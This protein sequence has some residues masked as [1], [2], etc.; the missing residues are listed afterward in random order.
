ML[1]RER[2]KIIE[3]QKRIENGIMD[4]DTQDDD[5]YEERKQEEYFDDDV[6]LGGFSQ[7]SA[8]SNINGRKHQTK[9]EKNLQ[10]QLE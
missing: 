1:A 7:R 8:I 6:S 10:S 4:D 9:F 2:R 5:S 3:E